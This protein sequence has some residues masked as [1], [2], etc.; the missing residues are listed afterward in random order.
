MLINELLRTPTQREPVLVVGLDLAQKPNP[1]HQVD[2]DG[3]V[4][5]G[6]SVQELILK[7]PG[8]TGEVDGSSIQPAAKLGKRFLS[9]GIP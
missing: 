1:V 7:H 2:R 5:L 4:A 9:G 8:S 3:D 6:E